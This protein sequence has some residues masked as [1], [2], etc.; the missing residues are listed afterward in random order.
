MVLL[1]LSL[2]SIISRGKLIVV[3]IRKYLQRR[4]SNT[5]LRGVSVNTTLVFKSASLV[6][7]IETASKF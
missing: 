2:C 7:N 4:Y 1:S 6:M 5:D 3:T